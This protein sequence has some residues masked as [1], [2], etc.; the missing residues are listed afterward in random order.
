M[1]AALAAAMQFPRASIFV[2]LLT[3]GLFGAPLANAEDVEAS[4]TEPQGAPPD[5]IPTASGW[6]DS[7]NP[8][9]DALEAVEARGAQGNSGEGA[10]GSQWFWASGKAMPGLALR[11]G[12]GIWW[13]DL[14]A[15]LIHLTQSSNELDVHFLG[16]QF[17]L[18][19]M[20]R[21]KPMKRL[22]LAAG[23]GADIY[24]LWNIHGDEWQVALALRT[25]AH[26]ALASRVGIFGTA[27]AY[28]LSTGGLE[29]GTYR[30]GSS[31]LPVLFSTGIEWRLQ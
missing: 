11:A 3:F 20:V 17:G 24:G 28:P 30:D 1:K 29:L 7:P 16:N 21:A 19:A 27:R 15:S 13:L 26:V 14:E 4:A 8:D 22:E 25:T 6:N 10:L 31:G 23:L 12:K 5:V 2:G 18:F 9:A